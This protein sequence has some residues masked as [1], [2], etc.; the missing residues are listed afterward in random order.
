M[1]CVSV[2]QNVEK[3]FLLQIEG[4]TILILDLSVGG[5]KY[6]SSGRLCS[7]FNSRLLTRDGTGWHFFLT[8]PTVTEKFF[9][10]PKFQKSSTEP[11]VADKICNLTDRDRPNFC[12]VGNRTESYLWHLIT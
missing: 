3:T 5:L 7:I 12:K 1:L 10:R 4:K 6:I 9:N 8:E 11:T 2:K